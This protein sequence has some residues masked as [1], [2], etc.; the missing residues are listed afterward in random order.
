MIEKK[1]QQKVVNKKIFDLVEVLG[2]KL[3]LYD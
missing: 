2:E 1:Y 3:K